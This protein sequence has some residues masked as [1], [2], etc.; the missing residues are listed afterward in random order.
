[1]NTFVLTIVT[2]TLLTI[3]SAGTLYFSF[4][5][6]V[7]TSG[8]Y[9]LLAESLWMVALLIAITLNI[10]QNFLTTAS[11]YTL[12]AITLFSE[13]SILL[14]IKALTKKIDAR[15]CAYW[16]LFVLMYCGFIEYCRNYISPRLPLLL[17]SGF[18]FCVTSFTYLACKRINSNGLENNLFIKWITYTE[19]GLTVIHV[20]RFSSYFTGTPMQPF[21]PAPLPTI[22]F[23]IWFSINLIRYFSYLALRV[24]WVDPRNSNENPLNQSLVKLAHEKDQFLQGLISSNRALGISALANSLAHQLSQPITGVILQTESVK[25]TLIEQGGQEKSIQLLDTVN[26]EL[27]KVSGLVNNLRKLFGAQ[28]VEFKKFNIQNAC[29]EVLEIIKP[30][31]HSKNIRL[32]K[33][34]ASNPSALGNSIHI[35]QVLIN[36]FNNAIDS[37]KSTS[38]QY[39]E[40]SLKV[41]QD[42]SFAIITIQD[43]GSGIADNIKLTMFDLYQ[44]TKQEGLGIGLWLSKTII[45]KHAGSITALNNPHGGAIFE[46]RIPLATDNT[47]RS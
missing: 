17:F 7:D 33:S 19:I 42:Q 21:N 35:Q 25:R 5:G 2:P 38:T 26:N 36:L 31:L 45:D 43:S 11:F 3:V 20:L 12:S 18:S 6:R 46:V 16:L 8:R 9:F 13:V 15:Q 34:Y 37:I 29:D 30:A 40:I 24:S 41:D 27:S 32:I 22:F 1:M 28:K 44:S 10:W 39:Q 14:S 4:K 23:S 47:G